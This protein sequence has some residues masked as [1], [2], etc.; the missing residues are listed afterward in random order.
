MRCD[1]VQSRLAEVASGDVLLL[2][3]EQ[4]HVERCLRCQAEL[5]QHRRVRQTMRA[6]RDNGVEPAPGVLRDVLSALADAGENG[7]VAAVRR[8]HRAAYVAGVAAVT[9]AGAVGAALLASRWRR[10]RA[11]SS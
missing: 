1:R 6:L 7:A 10:P 2:P 3:D 9:A 4:A 8:S 11:L 5:V